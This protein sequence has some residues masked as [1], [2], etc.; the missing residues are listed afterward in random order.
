[1]SYKILA[2]DPADKFGWALSNEIYG[3][4]DIRVKRDESIGM[5]FLRLET[6]LIEIFQ[7]QDIKLIAFERPGGRFKRDIINHSKLQGIIES[8]CAQHNLNHIGYSSKEIKK[9]ATNNGNCGKAL[10]ISSA[11]EKLNYSGNDNNEADALWILEL[12]KKEFNHLWNPV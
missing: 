2:L 3:V 12:A 5:K 9:F 1:M 10:M 6:K 11:R 8:F 4:W 7:T